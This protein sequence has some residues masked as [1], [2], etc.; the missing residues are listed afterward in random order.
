VRRIVGG[1]CTAQPS[2]FACAR[3]RCRSAQQARCL[4]QYPGD[5]ANARPVDL[6]PSP[7]AVFRFELNR[8]RAA[9]RP[10]SLSTV[11]RCVASSGPACAASCSA[12]SWGG[13]GSKL[14]VRA[15]WLL[16]SAP[17]I[18]GCRCIGGHLNGWPS[19]WEGGLA[20]A[21]HARNASKPTSP[22]S[23]RAR[24][25]WFDQPTCPHSQRYSR[26]V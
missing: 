9:A 23:R 26:D 20:G 15:D 14:R 21:A 19:I 11:R 22:N 10:W 4:A 12:S 1:V 17:S 16:D 6:R 2:T 8:L 25:M 13:I 5:G 3:S 24:S 18:S 7:V